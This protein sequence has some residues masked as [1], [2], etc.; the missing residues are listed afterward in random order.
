VNNLYKELHDAELSSAEAEALRKLITSHYVKGSAYSDI[1]SA[2]EEEAPKASGLKQYIPPADVTS[3]LALIIATLS[4]ADEF[5][6]NW[7]PLGKGRSDQ[8]A[9]KHGAGARRWPSSWVKLAHPPIVEE[10]GSLILC[11]SWGRS[12]HDQIL[13]L[14]IFTIPTVAMGPPDRPVT[15]KP[16]MFRYS[17]MSDPLGRTD[18]LPSFVL[19]LFV[20]DRSSVFG[21]N[22]SSVV[23]LEHMGA[24]AFEMAWNRLRSPELMRISTSK[25]LELSHQHER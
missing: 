18:H 24:L 4:L 20:A 8:G 1:V 11:G 22:N 5:V 9:A 16:G 7:T 13:S 23:R 17:L 21:I 10:L 2:I 6:A 25:W 15:D 14:H 3:A 19:L 12:A